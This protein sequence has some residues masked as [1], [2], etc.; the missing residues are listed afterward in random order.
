MLLWPGLLG[1]LSRWV[2]PESW[3]M[4]RLWAAITIWTVS[5][6]LVLAVYFKLRL[7]YALLIWALIQ[8]LLILTVW[9][10]LPMIAK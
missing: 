8:A 9:E 4:W 7:R 3:G 2:M 6:L 5:L 10:V 1:R